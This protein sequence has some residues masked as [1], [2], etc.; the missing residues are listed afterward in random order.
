MNRIFGI[1]LAAA[2]AL[3]VSAQD[4][5]YVSDD[6]R[7]T[8]RTGR[9]TDFQVL[10]TIRS[11]TQVKELETTDDGYSRV[12]LDDG[13]EGWVLN[14]YLVDTP[15]ARERLAKATEEIVELSEHNAR[16]QEEKTVL[17]QHKIDTDEELG[18]LH[19]EREELAAKLEHYKSLA[20][21]PLELETKNKTLQ[22]RIHDLERET[23]LLQEKSA[24]L[25]QE[26]ERAWFLTGG[27]VLLGGILLGLLIPRLRWKKRS[28]WDRF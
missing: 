8:V 9:G 17:E 16:L 1:V 19:E 15:I 6:L 23:R 14:R 10:R 4:V 27:G 2:A 12:Q 28:G 24:S 11:G 3:P 5:R 20:A 22:E 26:S 13:I 21:K 18:R 25:Q 7:V